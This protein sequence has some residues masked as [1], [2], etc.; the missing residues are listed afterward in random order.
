MSEPT[1][2]K[3]GFLRRFRWGILPAAVYLLIA[4][5]CVIIFEA[6]PHEYHP[7]M[8]IAAYLSYPVYVVLFVLLRRHT[9]FIERLPYGEAISCAM[10]LL[11]TAVLYFAVGLAVGYVVRRMRASRVSS[12][13]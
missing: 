6:D 12:R 4:L 13:G 7:A 9:V 11:V 10:L 3:Q 8:F 5:S 2:H 1:P